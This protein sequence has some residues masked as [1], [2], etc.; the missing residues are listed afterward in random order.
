MVDKS[1]V[2]IGYFLSLSLNKGLHHGYEWR[3]RFVGL[4]LRLAKINKHE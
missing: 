4:E 3:L 2:S 1:Y